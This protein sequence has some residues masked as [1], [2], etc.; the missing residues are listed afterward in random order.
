MRVNVEDKM[1]SDPRFKQLGQLLRMSHFEAFGRCLPVWLAAQ[2]RR[3][4]HMTPALIDALAERPG[5]ADAMISA[6]LADHESDDQVRLRGIAAR[7]VQ[8][9]DW[10]Q[11]REKAN[12]A[13]M[14]RKLAEL[15]VGKSRGEVP[16]GVPGGVPHIDTDT[17]SLSGSGSPIS[18]PPDLSTGGDLER[19]RRQEIRKKIWSHLA[20][21]RDDLAAELGLTVRPLPVQDSGERALAMWLLEAGDRGEDDAMHVISVYAAEARAT[22]SVQWVTGGMFEERSRR[23][24]LGMTTADA[25]RKARAAPTNDRGLTRFKLPES[26]P[27]L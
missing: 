6:G 8:L 24:A 12:E 3:S 21:V 5:F 19:S 15:P 26:E 4:E 16:W 27:K 7:L 9:R 10:D 1:L 25:A 13:K 23:R 11:K 18:L 22:R 2:Q 20:K 14:A 17:D